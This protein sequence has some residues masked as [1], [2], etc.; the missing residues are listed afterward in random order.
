LY[1]FS[2]NA[3][4]QR[5]ARK[6]KNKKDNNKSNQQEENAEGNEFAEDEEPEEED[7]GMN[8]EDEEGFF[9]EIIDTTNKNNFGSASSSSSSYA[10][11]RDQSQ[12]IFAQMNLSR[13]F[14]R[15][16]EN[17]GYTH[18]TP[19]QSQVIP[20]ALAG[21]DICA[22]AVTGSG[23]TVAFLLP[24]L[25][26]LF[27]R[28]RDIPAIRVLVITPTRELATQ[29]HEVFTK[30]AQFT[31]ISGTLICGGKKDVRSQEVIL[32]SQPDLVICTPGRMLDHLRNSLNINLDLLNI[33]ILD[34]VDRLLEMGFQDEVEE[35]IKY[36]PFSRQTMLFSATMTP[37]IEDLIKLSL[38]RPVRIKTESSHLTVA[39]RLIQEFVKVKDK[40]D[41]DAIL[42]SL[43]H[44]G[45]SEK[46]I[47][48][49]ELKRDAHRFCAVLNLSGIKAVELHGDLPQI[50]RYMS[51]ESFRMGEVD[52]MVA[53]DVAARGI[54]I[55]NVQTV[56]NAAM[57][58]N[59]S[60][61][62][63]R[64]GRTARAGCG[65]RSITLVTDERRKIMK[66]V[67]KAEAKR[68]AELKQLEKQGKQQQ[69]KG[70]EEEK[71]K[72]KKEEEKEEEEGI[73][74]N[75]IL[76]RS[77]P[78]QV[79]SHYHEKITNLEGQI[80][81][82]MREEG[83]RRRIEAAEREAERAENLLLHHE[84][85][86]SRPARTWFQTLTQKKEIQTTVLENV[87]QEREALKNHDGERGSEDE[88]GNPKK[89]SSSR[90]PS[91]KKWNQAAL[92]DDY[93]IDENDKENKK[94]LQHRVSRKK[95][96][97]LEALKAS[98]AADAEEP[99]EY[100]FID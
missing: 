33:L 21:R 46:T 53:T 27:Y 79:I 62:V 93:R 70:T 13:P 4:E 77:I 60:I 96:R 80:G 89:K 15:A 6:L 19:I 94:L 95:R 14:L 54:D 59:V 90:L 16:I 35:L 78:S 45:F 42:L 31:D 83:T 2:Q 82:Y 40:Q 68:L 47:V 88:E 97:R 36:V 43:I 23:K 22:S 17:L 81:Q 72:K 99:G 66:D 11:L 87:R 91:E 32:R 24:S 28:P 84:E 50:Q 73:T 56:I 51:L 39:P 44:R 63:H 38:K 20:F 74:S 75:Q 85:I 92:R 18:P 58:R 76:S 52:V 86:Q 49:F 34:E 12:I 71:E 67:L 10:A 48:F 7:M 98:E 65:G 29:I 25:E 30:L 41:I 61:Y 37:K 8:A 9:E 100:L 5:I 64:V 69:E 3:V 55:A 1:F 57:P 26:R